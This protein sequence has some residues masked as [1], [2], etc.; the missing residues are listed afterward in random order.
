MWNNV[1]LGFGEGT[2]S[3][4]EKEGDLACETMSDLDAGSTTDS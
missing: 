4:G 2:G 1:V 3:R